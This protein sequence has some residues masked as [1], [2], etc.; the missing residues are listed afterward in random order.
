[1]DNSAKSKQIIITGGHL[2]PA[3]SLL[4]FLLD[5]GFTDISWIGIKHSQTFTRVPSAEYKEVTKR[6]I[7]FFNLHAGK[8]W[9]KW[10]RYTLVKAFFN[11]ILIPVGFIQ[12]FIIIWR[13]KPALV[14]S[15]G[16]YLALPVVFAAWLFEIKCITHE[17]TIVAGLSNRLIAKMCDK[18]MVS[19]ESN[20]KFY[21]EDKVVLTGNPVLK[22]IFNVTTNKFN[23]EKDL[24]VI[25]FTGG[26]QGSNTINWRLFKVLPKL[27]ESVN[28]IHQT[29]NSTITKDFEKAKQAYISLPDTLKRRYIYFDNTFGPEIGEVF[30]KSDLIVCRA[31]AN[32]VNDIV[33]LG[34]YALFIPIPWASHNEQQLN[35]EY[36]VSKGCGEIL[37][38]RD[39]M[40]PEEFM[41]AVNTALQN[42]LKKKSTK[43]HAPLSSSAVE[44][45]YNVIEQVI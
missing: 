18:V 21:P 35:A 19:W 22:D 10:T 6:G 5:K 29:G 17:Q 7:K 14:V 37:K 39:D 3:L 34:K 43:N 42:A 27:L 41:K 8:I 11:T 33:T 4:D 45:I 40:K 44:K 16:G 30:N 12:A 20:L 13:R 15:F 23:L 24:P 38:Q 26:N 28:I 32:T 25:Y 1:M 9:R 31:G 2:T 36:A